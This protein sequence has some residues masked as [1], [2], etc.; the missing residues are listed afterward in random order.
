MASLDVS[1]IAISSQFDSFKNFDKAQ[2]AFTVSGTLAPSASNTWETIITL[3]RPEA[4]GQIYARRSDA[5]NERAPIP[6][7]NGFLI[8]CTVSGIGTVA[9]FF[10]FY[11]QYQT[12]SLRIYTVQRNPYASNMSIPSTTLTFYVTKFLSPFDSV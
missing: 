2:G 9:M 1:K 7:Y 10:G 11:I 8:N 12:N 3:E 5:P 4:L 6:P